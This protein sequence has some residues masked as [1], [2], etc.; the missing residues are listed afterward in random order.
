MT[1]KKKKKKKKKM[2]GIQKFLRLQIVL[3]LLLL[4]F[5]GVYYGSGIGGKVTKLHREAVSLVNNSSED[6]FKNSQTSL[7][8]DTNGDLLATL[9]GDKGVYYLEFDSIPTYAKNAFVSIEDKKFYRHHGV[10]FLAIMRAATSIIQNRSI[11][12]GASTITQ[13]LARNMFLSYQV[14]WERKVEEIFIAVELEKEYSKSQILEFYINNINF[15]NGYY[16]IQAASKGYFNTEVQN[17]SLSQIA[18]LCAIPNNPTFYDPTDHMDN[19]LARRNRILKQMLDDGKISSDE[20]QGAISEEITLNVAKK[21]EKHNYAE[22]Y[23]YYCATKALMEKR[24]FVFEYDFADDEAKKK[25]KEEFDT[26]YEECNSDLH[27]GGYKIYTSINMDM[28]NELQK[29]IDDKLYAFVTT[30]EE[31]TYNMQAAGTCI[32]NATGNVVAIVGGRKQDTSGY[33]L[34]R[35]FQSFRQPGSSIKPLI[36]Y[37]PSL[38]RGYTPNSTVVDEPIK[39]GPKNFSGGYAGSISLRYAVSKSINTIAWKLFEDLTP[40]VGLSYLTNMNFSNIVESDYHTAA[41]LGGL[42]NGV[43]TVE[44]ASAYETIEN[45]GIYRNPTCITKITDTK[46]EII[47]QNAGEEKEVYKKNAAL[48]MTDILTSVMKEGTGRAL[49]LKG[50]NSAGKTG[51]TN[52]SKDGWFCGFTPYY[53]TS[54]WVGCDM[55]KSVE[56]LTGASYPGKIWHEYMTAIHEGLENKK[57]LTYVSYPS[58]KKS[59]ETMTTNTDTPAQTDQTGTDTTGTTD[60]TETD[61]TGT[62]DQ[63]GTDTTGTTDQ[64]GT[65]TTGTT[66]QTGMD[67]TGANDPKGKKKKGITGQ[68]GADATGV[69]GQDG[70]KSKGKNTTEGTIDS[71]QNN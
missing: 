66:D 44:M 1:D 26:L 17:L 28:Q 24:G 31:G 33:T 25:Y 22:T 64:T 67:T 62:T 43:S 20:Y 37:T 68:T 59:V 5:L 35:A 10:D 49:Q 57:F 46:G 71:S 30:N 65:D 60:Q 58:S 51:T 40:A 61:T 21:I 6:T 48:M 32:D 12:Q 8:Y 63:T 3:L 14:S 19:T 54:I 9:K 27:T 13:Q 29:A 16:G 47:Y 52:D 15:G 50:M 69:T 53:T 70:Q 55:P 36:V 23:I 2:R 18:F 56:G 39:D 4:V 34:N 11:T 7:V 42:T 38:E 41:A 45:Q